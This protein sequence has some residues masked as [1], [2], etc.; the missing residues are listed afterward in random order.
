MRCARY[1]PCTTPECADYAILCQDCEKKGVIETIRTV[2]RRAI[3]PEDHVDD[4]NW[5]GGE[6]WRH[7]LDPLAKKR[8]K[9]PKNVFTWRPIDP[10][11]VY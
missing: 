7:P 1:F 8:Q 2:I 10:G 6:P 11:Q 9:K 4:P 5:E 3:E